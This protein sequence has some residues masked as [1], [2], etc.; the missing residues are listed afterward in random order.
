[1]APVCSL[2]GE[3][4][5]NEQWPLPA[6]LFG[7]KLPSPTLTLVPN[8]SVPLYMFLVPFNPLYQ[9]WTQKKSESGN[10]VGPLRGTAQDS[11]S[12]RLA[13]SHFL[14]FWLSFAARSQ[15]DFSSQHWNP[16]LGV[17]VWVWN[18]SLLSLGG[19]LQPTYPLCFFAAT[20]VYGNSP[21]SISAPPASLHMASSLIY[22]LWDF[23]AADFRWI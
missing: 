19:H 15:G 13:Q 10:S 22:Q 11:R 23:Y 14:F 8:T 18:P 4:S 2:C 3:C 1:M 16:G 21:F 7:R 17:L 6:L 5:S 12:L 20:C 9:C